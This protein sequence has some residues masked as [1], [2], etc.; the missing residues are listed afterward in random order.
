MT[1]FISIKD[2]LVRNNFLVH[3]NDISNRIS[4]QLLNSSLDLIRFQM[5]TYF[6]KVNKM[7]F[8]Y[9]MVFEKHNGFVT[10]IKVRFV[11]G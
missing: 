2:E 1:D 10:N 4:F 6:C 5:S 8:R 11:M 3:F 7:Y 9:V